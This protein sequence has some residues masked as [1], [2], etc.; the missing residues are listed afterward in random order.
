[1]ESLDSTPGQS[2]IM[3]L[4]GFFHDFCVVKH[5][6]ISACAAELN[7][8]SLEVRHILSRLVVLAETRE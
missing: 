2:M 5:G 4:R 7:L 3:K 1:M 8:T 6:S